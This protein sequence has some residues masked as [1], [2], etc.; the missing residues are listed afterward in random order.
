LADN[1]GTLNIRPVQILW[2][3]ADSVLIRDGIVPGA[4]LIVSDL[5]TPVAG[6]AIQVDTDDAKSVVPSANPPARPSQG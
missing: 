4:Q 1:N 6:M 5:A 2:R 3:D